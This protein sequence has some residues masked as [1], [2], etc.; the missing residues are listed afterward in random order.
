MAHTDSSPPGP[1][2]TKGVPLADI[3][4]TGALAGHVDGNPA[5]LVRLDDGIHAVS[6]SCTHYGAPLSEGLV[7]ADEIRCP[8]HHAC[9][10]LRTGA[11]LRAPAFAALTS[12]RV[13]VVGQTAFVRAGET[14]EHPIQPAQRP[15]PE[16]IVIIGGGAAGFAAALR[17]RELGYRGALT[18]LSDDTSA[19]Y[20]RPN[21][22][23]DYLAGTAQEE[24]MPLQGPDFYA[25]R[26]IDL[27]LDC[28]V[29]AI[30]TQARQVMTVAGEPLAYDAL[31]IAT[32]AQPRRLPLPGFERPNVFV[33][34][35]MA[36]AQAIIE[37][38]K[39]ATSVALVGAG[40]IGMEAAAAL[41][42][43][44]L[45][46]HVVAPEEVP[47]E[48][49]LGRDVGGFITS[50][51]KE[52]GVVFHLRSAVKDFDGNLLTLADGTSI[53]A[54]LVL[55]G[56]GVSPRTD[57]AKAAGLAVDD[58][59]LVDA[60]LQTSVAGIFA[61]GDVARYQHA[62]ER[63]R[64]EHWVHAQRQGQTVAA[65]M[66]GAGQAFTDVPFFWTH[67]YGLDLR[68]TGFAGGWDDVRIDG[69]LAQRDFTARFLRAATLVAAISAGRDLENL[70]IEA[71]LQ[72]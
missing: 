3:P 49:A 60:T 16:R 31:L 67:H 6:G 13:E 20:D 26:Q 54:Q 22:S 62:G 51:H 29:S 56:T 42:S 53:A 19:P 14:L 15:H 12:W 50:L 44:G 66:L 5:L 30:D 68:Y 28:T 10:S 21:L 71:A 34:R 11:A 23:K 1:D 41:R 2:L 9:F 61:A 39:G 8:W 69:S 70:S 63:I 57:L 45:E 18:M 48:H 47:M 38:S 40:F 36:D 43:R 64:V 27:R 4:A 25:D 46:V 35:S 58:G 55:L 37:A 72:V 59:I 52:Q 33:L 24:W 7:V 32:G 65:N 17:L